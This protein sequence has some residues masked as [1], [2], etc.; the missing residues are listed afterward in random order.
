MC[1]MQL[2]LGSST[3]AGEISSSDGWYWPFGGSSPGAIGW[4]LGLLPCV[5]F[6]WLDQASFPTLW[7][8]RAERDYLKSWSYKNIASMYKHLPNIC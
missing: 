5:L 8:L 3:G 2:Q 4:V 7:W 6:T 1:S